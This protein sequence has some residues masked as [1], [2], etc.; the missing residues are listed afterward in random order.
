MLLGVIKVL[1]VARDRPQVCQPIVFLICHPPLLLRRAVAFVVT[2][3]ISAPYELQEAASLVIVVQVERDF[4][5]QRSKDFKNSKL[6]NYPIPGFYTR[7][8]GPTKFNKFRLHYAVRRIKPI[9]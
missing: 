1:Q 6:W 3:A 7:F 9:L 8:F 4:F 5:F 2:E